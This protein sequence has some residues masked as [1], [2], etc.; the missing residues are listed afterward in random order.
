MRTMDEQLCEAGAVHTSHARQARDGLADLALTLEDGQREVPS[1]CSAASEDDCL[2]SVL[3]EELGTVR[4]QLGEV[5]GELQDQMGSLQ[6]RL[7]EIDARVQDA[8]H[9]LQ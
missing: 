3:R 6:D 1:H 9:D 2:E 5:Q 7:V 4:A 8:E